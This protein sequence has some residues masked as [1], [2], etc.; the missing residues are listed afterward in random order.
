MVRIDDEPGGVLFLAAIHRMIYGDK[1]H[2]TMIMRHKHRLDR[3]FF[4]GI[5]CN[6]YHDAPVTGSRDARGGNV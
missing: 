5:S 1:T 6:I 4:E 2:M 3:A